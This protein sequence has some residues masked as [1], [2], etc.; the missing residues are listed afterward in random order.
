MSAESTVPR[1]RRAILF[2]ALGGFAATAA[3]IVHAPITRAG[4]DGDVV[5]DGTNAG[6]GTTEIDGGAATVFKV[7]GSGIAIEASVAAG[8][9]AGPA[10][11]GLGPG[12]I[13]PLT[14]FATG[15]Y[16][17]AT[18]AGVFGQTGDGFGVFGHSDSV[19]GVYGQGFS[20]NHPT[21]T[22][23]VGIHGDAGSVGV[24]GSAGTLQ[25]SQLPDP[26]DA[27]T[28]VYGISDTGHGVYG[29]SDT[30]VGVYAANNAS[31]VAAIV[32]EGGPGTAIHGHAAVGPV[33]AS[34]GLTGVYGS[35]PGAGVAI[36]A[37]SDAGLAIRATS[38]TGNG[39]RGHGQLDG[40]IG[41]S[42]SGRSGVVG[43]S[44]GGS[45]PAG[46]SKTGVYGEA[47]Q[48]ASSHGVYGYALA[49]QGVRGDATSGQGMY[50][51]ATTGQGAR[52]EASGGG[53]GVFGQSNGVS[54][55]R[56]VMGKSDVGQAVRGEATTGIGV[57]AVATTGVALAV[58]GRATF[59]RSG[60]V[61]I[62]AASTSVDV[63]VPGGIASNA[64][65]FAA[66]QYY[67]SGVYVAAARINYPTAGKLRIYLNKAPGS[68]TALAWF[69]FG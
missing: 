47:T 30:G 31:T 10:V 37:D 51:T 20:G 16:G 63:T 53:V 54:G 65:A 49:G 18:D 17:S 36:A 68:T 40:V 67:R 25:L 43:F 44:G 5:L 21:H 28:G 23:S 24:I 1:T 60:K 48:D 41:E 22:P 42:G 66:M 58:S 59:S 3:S 7:A 55:A 61:N 32:A 27:H 26:V 35:A 69:V 9:S 19:D 15:V 50:G 6:A 34:P 57:Q 8:P 13:D 29:A 38:A 4:V 39:I 45:A 56:G 52:G 64:M 2:G 12:S 46:P 14:N 62:G 11:A 33:P